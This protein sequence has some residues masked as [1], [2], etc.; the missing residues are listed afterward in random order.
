[1]SVRARVVFVYVNNKAQGR[2]PDDLGMAQ[3]NVRAC[4]QG[5]SCLLC[6]SHGSQCRPLCALVV[7][8]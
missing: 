7:S 3:Q 4:R 5:M 2:R 1:V 8:I 6:T